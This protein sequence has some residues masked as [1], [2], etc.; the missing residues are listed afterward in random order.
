MK[1]KITI[2]IDLER[3]DSD[4]RKINNLIQRF[5]FDLK[6]EDGVEVLKYNLIKTKMVNPNG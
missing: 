5:V 3:I 6:N 4:V 2:E 1:D